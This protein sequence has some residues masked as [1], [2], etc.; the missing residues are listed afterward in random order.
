MVYTVARPFTASGVD[1][2][3][4]QQLPDEVAR[5]LKLSALLSNRQLLP[6]IDPHARRGAPTARRSMP[7]TIV[8]KAYP[9]DGGAGLRSGEPEGFEVEGKTV[10]QVL[11]EVGDDAAVAQAACDAESAMDTP[12]VT[13][14]N[15]LT[16]II[17][18]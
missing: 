14:I 18:A 2:T 15:A 6:D 7:T 17:N 5:T 11:G 16:G 4:G 9:L 3:V 8:P 13:L 1:Y 10:Q 12:R